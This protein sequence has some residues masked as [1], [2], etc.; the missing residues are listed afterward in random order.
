MNNLAY[1]LSVVLL[2]IF[3]STA[4]AAPPPSDR[5]GNQDL[6]SNPQLLHMSGHGGRKWDGQW[7]ADLAKKAATRNLLDPESAR[8][9]DTYITADDNRGGLCGE[10][11]SKNQFGAYSGYRRFIVGTVG[12]G[13]LT[14]V[15]EPTNRRESLYEFERRLFEEQWKNFCVTPP[16]QWR[17]WRDATQ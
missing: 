4:Y 3:C 11:N 5:R 14:P 13:L 17:D 9:R 12:S 1:L 7:F 10:I 8:F 15:F 2:S 16:V 6:Q